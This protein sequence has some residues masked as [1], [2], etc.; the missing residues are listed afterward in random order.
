MLGRATLVMKKSMIGM[1]ALAKAALRRA[2]AGA[3]LEH[4]EAAGELAARALAG[5]D[6]VAPGRREDVA[7]AA[8]V[9]VAGADAAVADAVAARHG[10]SG[11]VHAGTAKQRADIR[12]L[13][14]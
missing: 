2:G 13:P 3:L 8:G 10:V 14:T 7:L 5:D 9:L 11:A 6:L 4:L 12:G 1:K